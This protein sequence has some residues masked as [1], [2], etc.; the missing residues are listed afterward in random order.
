MNK[1]VSLTI[2]PAIDLNTSVDNVIVEIKLRCSA[3]QREPGGGGINVS[4]AIKKLGGHSVALYTSGGLTGQMLQ[5]LLDSEDLENL[6]IPIK[7]ITR[8][9][10]IVYEESTT[11]QYRLCMPGPAL[12]KSE[13]KY[14]LDQITAMDP[15][16]DYIVASGSL[17][18]NTPKNFYAKVAQV[19]KEMGS[20][21]I[22]DTHGVPLKLALQA[23]VFLIKPNFKE[24]SQ[25]AGCEIKTEKQMEEI[26]KE[27][28]H[29][30]QTEIVVISLGAAGVLGVSEQM[31]EYIRSPA[32]IIR[33]KVGAGDSMI[34]GIVLKLAEGWDVKDAINYGVAAGTAAVMTRGTEL[35]RLEDTERLYRELKH[36]KDNSMFS[37]DPLL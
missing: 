14:I 23:G 35:C 24:L 21:V 19:G 28:I 26:A 17:P 18:P 30:G 16:P 2:N 8:E 4:R 32:V 11:H 27:L 10:I 12:T 5:D 15:I 25:L 29:S 31:C 34:G 33:S 7:D 3:P 13:H 36:F 9:N 37:N 6:P 22:V 1:V 20:K